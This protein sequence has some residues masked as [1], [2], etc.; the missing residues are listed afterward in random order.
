MFFENK[1]KDGNFEDFGCCKLT[2]ST[3]EKLL[4]VYNEKFSEAGL[5]YSYEIESMINQ[6]NVPALTPTVTWP[7]TPGRLSDIVD[8][9]KGTSCKEAWVDPKPE[10]STYTKYE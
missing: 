2:G 4:T 5:T 6:T 9:S 10:E 7:A 3:L 8:W 1:D